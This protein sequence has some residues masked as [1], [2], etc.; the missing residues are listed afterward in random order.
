MIRNIFSAVLVLISFAVQASECEI[1]LPDDKAVVTDDFHFVCHW[2][3]NS[4]LILQIATDETFS[5]IIYAGSSKWML[6]NDYYMQ[7]LMAVTNFQ[8]GTYYWRIAKDDAFSQVRSFTVEGRPDV[9]A[10]YEVVRDQNDYPIVQL[11]NGLP[12]ITIASMWIR[13][14]L[15][16]NGLG[17]TDKGAYNTSMVVKDGIVYVGNGITTAQLYRYNAYTG[18]HLSTIDIDFGSYTRPTSPLADMCM[19]DDGNVIMTNRANSKTERYIYAHRVDVTTGKVTGEYKCELP[20]ASNIEGAT[21]YRC[22]IK[23]SVSTGDFTI[24]S[25][26][27]PTTSYS[28]ACKWEFANWNPKLETSR[29][30]YVSTDMNTSRPSI[31]PIDEDY[32]VLDDNKYNYPTIFSWNSNTAVAELPADML[33]TDKKCMGVELFEHSGMNMIAYAS[34]VNGGSKFNIAVLPDEFPTTFNGIKNLWTL[35]EQS[36][37]TV[38]PTVPGMFARVVD[39]SAEGS[40][41]SRSYLYLYSSGNGLG[42]YVLSHATTTGIDDVVASETEVNLNGRNL[43]LT[44][45]VESIVIYDIY[46]RKIKQAEN[47]SVI[48]LQDISLGVYIAKISNSNKVYK[49]VLK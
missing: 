21:F 11:S 43:I 32:F 16:N 12:P 2:D 17:Q 9:S 26:V 14:D 25:A 44:K 38:S 5:D 22:M 19:D 42:A 7:Y 33:P 30:N 29:F 6:Y 41:T 1:Y 8:N 3:D 20:L 13:S 48:G 24:Y 37:G 31:Y 47:T 18:E 45:E 35:P 28:T 40:A 34:S 36:L 4:N 10:E 23:G 15:N 46:G 27:M 39:M 49:F